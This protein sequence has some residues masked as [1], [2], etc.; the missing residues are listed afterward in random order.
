MT[1]DLESFDPGLL[2]LVLFGPGFGESVVVRVPPDI[3]IVVDSVWTQGAES[4]V[5]PALELMRRYGERSSCIVFTHPHQ[6]HAAGLDLLVNRHKEGPVGA[7]TAIVDLQPSAGG[8]S[9]DAQRRLWQGQVEHALAAIQTRWETDPTS[10]WDLVAGEERTIGQATIRPLY[11][12]AEAIDE[13]SGAL[14][15]DLNRLST[16]LLFEWGDARLILGAD[17]PLREWEQVC[18][19]SSQDLREHNALKIA[20]HGSKGA[21]HRCVIASS[22]SGRKT[23][24]CTPWNRGM[25]LPRFETGEGIEILLDE[26]DALELT[27][28]PTAVNWSEEGPHT[29]TRKEILEAIEHSKFANLVLE[30]GN[31]E[32]SEAWLAVGLDRAGNRVDL[33]RGSTAVTVTN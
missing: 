32:P 4:K 31:E 18:R 12:S 16:P 29:A 21:Q 14:P 27:A 25:G 28:L 7:N 2:Y 24:F 3:W 15:D 22:D 6:D 30:Y 9:S 23:W 26:N 13:F 33:R 11:P 17:L 1:D 20:H 19:A 10:R 8:G 5:V